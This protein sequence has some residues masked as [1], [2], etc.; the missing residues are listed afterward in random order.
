VDL[1]SGPLHCSIDWCT[2]CG[3]GSEYHLADLAGNG[4]RWKWICMIKKDGFHSL[5]SSEKTTTWIRP[6]STTIKKIQSTSLTHPG[7]KPVQPFLTRKK[8]IAYWQKGCREYRKIR[9][10]GCSVSSMKRKCIAGENDEK[11][12]VLTFPFY[13]HF[14]LNF[15][16]DER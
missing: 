10:V 9:S 4:K 2:H 8:C 5:L 14:K 15:V 12:K 1:Q 13:R 3:F 6:I 16:F 7:L 11:E